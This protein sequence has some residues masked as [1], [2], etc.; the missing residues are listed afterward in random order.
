M[1]DEF[2]EGA[3]VPGIP[4]G[5]DARQAAGGNQATVGRKENGE[6]GGVFCGDARQLAAVAQVPAIDIRRHCSGDQHGV[7]GRD[8]RG[9]YLLFGSECKPFL[10]GLRVPHFRR[11]LLIAMGHNERALRAEIVLRWIGLEPRQRKQGLQ[12]G[13]VE[14]LRLRGAAG[15]D[16]PRAVGAEVAPREQRRREPRERPLDPAREQLWN[17]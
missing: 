16:D 8:G 1:S 6:H 10:A 17:P 5:G 4:D 2:G 11:G 7:I 13:G 12:G 9:D 15:Q 14:H 3:A